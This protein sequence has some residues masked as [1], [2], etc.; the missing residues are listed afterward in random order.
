MASASIIYWCSVF[1]FMI[2][3]FGIVKTHSPFRKNQK[4]SH[5][6][7]K[8]ISD[9]A[10]PPPP[11]RSFYKEKKQFFFLLMPPL[12]LTTKFTMKD[13]KHWKQKLVLLLFFEWC[14]TSCRQ[15]NKKHCHRSWSSW[16]SWSSWS[17]VSSY[18]R[19]TSSKS[20]VGMVI[21]SELGDGGRTYLPCSLEVW[22]EILVWK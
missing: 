19:I 16:P 11:F 2:N 21:V 5:F 1:F 18:A 7:D 3:P 22:L 13:R 8:E 12:M 10:S 20:A 15:T 9:W 6:S 17:S 14:L 4:I